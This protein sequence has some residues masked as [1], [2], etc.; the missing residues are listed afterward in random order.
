MRKLIQAARSAFL[1][2]TPLAPRAFDNARRRET[3]R[4]IVSRLSSGNFRL[5]Q[6]RFS[7]REDIDRDRE[8]VLAHK[9]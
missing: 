9:L 8:R 6:G 5:R 2:R 3:D 4:M 7:T 1:S